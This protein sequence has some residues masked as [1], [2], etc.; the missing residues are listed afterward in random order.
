MGV[1][2]VLVIT[3]LGVWQ[4]MPDDDAGSGAVE[5]VADEIAA[6]LTADDVANQ[7]LHAFAAGDIAEAGGLT[8]DVGAATTQLA[9]VRRTLAP[10]AVLA[11]RTGTDGDGTSAVARFT[12]T[13]TWAADR[14]WSYDSSVNLTSDG[15][16]WRIHWQPGIVHPRLSAGQGLVVRDQTG[17]PAVLDR[18]G[19]PLLTW[20]DAGTS[21]AAPATAP[22][23][24]P[25]M[26]RVASDQGAVSS[27]YVALVDAA[28]ADVEILH[29]GRAAPLT[30]TVS[31]PVQQAAQAAVDSQRLPTM[32]V[33]VQPSTG[34][35]LA[36]AQNAAAGS[37]P[38]ALNGLYPP[39]STFKIV[40]AA[41]L[42]D[43]GTVGVDTV[44]PCPGSATVGSRTVRNADFALGEV[45]LRTAFAQ[46]CNTTFAVRA[47]DLAPGD[48]PAAAGRLGLDADFEIPGI[49]TELGDVPA[50]RNTAEQVENSIGQGT[51]Q[52]SCLGLALVSAT[53]ASGRELTPR[54]W[55]ELDT[56]VNLGY[57]A[58]SARVTGSLRTMMR[59]VVTEGRGGA[60]AGYG[61][62][63][64]KTGTAQ[65][66]DGSRAHGWFTG[67]RDDLAFATLVLD[68]STSNAAVEVTGTFLGALG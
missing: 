45:P 51:V 16:R 66:G 10:E 17:Q 32:L 4:V 62:V 22:L 42:L 15:E 23:L 35:I 33:A 29:G 53:V 68:G 56:K 44:L 26:G 9:D 65:V 30:A 46:S 2:L 3:G 13:W 31:R 20:T 61:D 50:A 67:Y 6:Q 43:S 58:P 25:G 57:R 37:D 48:L 41:A 63:H 38:V 64:G 12:L 52:A 39:G 60:L 36:V 34:D 5:P 18:S 8:D 1:V 47:A 59:A 55:R 28:A 21:A 49:V 40:T 11:E 54:L 19:A 14:S 27:W 7:F 24:L